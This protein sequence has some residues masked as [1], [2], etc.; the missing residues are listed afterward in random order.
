VRA[1]VVPHMSVAQKRNM[2]MSS[3]QAGLD[4]PYPNA[5]A[6]VNARNKLLYLGLDEH[7]A[8]I[9]ESHG[10][11]EDKVK[12][13]EEEWKVAYEIGLT[14]ADLVLMKMKMEMEALQSPQPQPGAGQGQIGPG[15]QGQPEMAAQAAG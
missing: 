5:R 7:E 8:S 3:G 4:P 10:P 12:I 2:V 11:L 6:E 9:A 1:I 15:G 14:Q 13:A